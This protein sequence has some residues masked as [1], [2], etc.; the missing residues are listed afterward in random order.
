MNT[1]KFISPRTAI[2]VIALVLILVAS[3]V[4]RADDKPEKP[5]PLL[6][7]RISVVSINP[8]RPTDPPVVITEPIEAKSIWQAAETAMKPHYARGVLS[9]HI[10]RDVEFNS[11]VTK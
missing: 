6:K 9:L 11:T 8:E 10:V 1:S 4:L 7:Y 3:L 5:E 2:I